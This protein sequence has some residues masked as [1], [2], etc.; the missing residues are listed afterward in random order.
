M[1]LRLSRRTAGQRH[2]FGLLWAARLP[3]R[4]HPL[5][6]PSFH[7]SNPRSMPSHHHDAEADVLRVAEAV[8]RWLSRV[9]DPTFAS[10]D[11]VSPT[12]A[13]G[14]CWPCVQ[15]PRLRGLLR[16]GRR[17]GR[18]RGLGDDNDC[19]GARGCRGRWVRHRSSGECGVRRTRTRTLRS[20]CIR[21]RART[22][23]P[24]VPGVASRSSSAEMDGLTFAVEHG[25]KDL[26]VA[27][28]PSYGL[29]RQRCAVWQMPRE[30]FR[31]SV[32]VHDEQHACCR[33]ERRRLPR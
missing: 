4:P 28:D 15:A 26:G 14:R 20:P 24:S 22:A 17:C 29:G 7:P 18:P 10:V 23:R 31:H 8:D 21:H 33:R 6:R 32:V 3:L 11:A 13:D 1:R 9:P 16:L 12:D 30:G 5:H 27:C 25:W 2:Q 19:R